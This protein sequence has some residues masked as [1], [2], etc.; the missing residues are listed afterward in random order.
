VLCGMFSSVGLGYFG[1]C[2]DEYLACMFASGQLAI[3][4]MLLCGRWYFH[5]F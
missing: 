3:L 4:G 1:L 2:L 5:A